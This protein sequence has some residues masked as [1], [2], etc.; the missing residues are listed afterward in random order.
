VPEHGVWLT[1]W[2]PTHACGVLEGPHCVP[3]VH[4]MHALFTQNGVLGVHALAHSPQLAGS[5]VSL[6]QTLEQAVLPPVVHDCTHCVPLHVTV[7]PVGAMHTEQLGPHALVSLATH[8]LPHKCVPPVHWHAPLTQCRPP[9][10]WLPHVLQLLSSLVRSTQGPLHDVYVAAHAV[11]HRLATH[12][13]TACARVV[14]HAIPHAPQLALLLVV[15][16]HAIPH[17]IGADDGQPDWHEKPPAIAGAHNGAAAGHVVPQAP[18][19]GLIDKSVWQPAP[20]SAQSA[21]PAAHW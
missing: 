11:V 16:T 9:V 13:P 12:W 8:W 2:L 18:Q 20:A 3:D 10:H 19:F 14:V 7:P 6:T 1:H 17:G 5:F 15:L 21:W 4:S